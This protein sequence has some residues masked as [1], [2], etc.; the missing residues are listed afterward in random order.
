[1]IENYVERVSTYA[2]DIDGLIL[3]IA[4]LVTL[5]LWRRQLHQLLRVG[6]E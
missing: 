4:G 1:M 5:L 6:E 2:G 3:L